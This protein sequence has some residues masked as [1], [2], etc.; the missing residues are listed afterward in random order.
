MKEDLGQLPPI[1]ASVAAERD[2]AIEPEHLSDAQVQIQR[3]SRTTTLRRL[4]RQ[5]SAVVGLALLGFLFACALLA[6]V[7]APFNPDQ[8]MLDVEKGARPR[9]PPCIHILG[10]PASQAE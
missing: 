1:A 2:A 10:C 9:T 7:L 4:L 8:S 3:R 5:R 6:D